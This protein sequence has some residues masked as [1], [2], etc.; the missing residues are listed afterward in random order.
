METMEIEP[1]TRCDEFLSYHETTNHWV[2]QPLFPI[3]YIFFSLQNKDTPAFQTDPKAGGEQTDLMS[4]LNRDMFKGSRLYFHIGIYPVGSS[5]EKGRFKSDGFEM[6]SNDLR[7]AATCTELFS[8][9]VS[10]ERLTVICC[11]G[12]CSHSS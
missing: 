3:S 12:R 10:N 8:N 2:R 6:L 9:G 11:N 5:T 1:P 7:G 4:F